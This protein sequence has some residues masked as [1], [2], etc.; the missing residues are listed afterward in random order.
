[1]EEGQ[2]PQAA[3]RGTD[4]CVVMKNTCVFSFLHF[5]C[6]LRMRSLIV[7]LA[8]LALACAAPMFAGCF[9]GYSQTA[10]AIALSPISY[11]VNVNV[12]YNFGCTGTLRVLMIG[13]WTVYD[14]TNT[15]LQYQVDGN[16]TVVGTW[17]TIYGDN[18]A[19]LLNIDVDDEYLTYGNCTG[20]F[21]TNPPGTLPYDW[22]SNS[23]G[24]SAV[25][26]GMYWYSQQVGYLTLIPDGPVGAEITLGGVL[27][28]IA[29]SSSN[30]IWG[31]K[32]MTLGPY[33]CVTCAP[34]TPAPSTGAPTPPPTPP[35]TPAPLPPTPFPGVPTPAPTPAPPT[36]APPTPAPTPAPGAPAKACCRSECVLINPSDPNQLCMEIPAASSCPAGYTLSNTGT[37]GSACM[38]SPCV[39]AVCGT[40]GSSYIP[41]CGTYIYYT[42]ATFN[43]P[44]YWRAFGSSTD[45]GWCNSFG[46]CGGCGGGPP[47]PPP[48]PAPTPPAPTPAPATQAC[49]NTQTV[50][51]PATADYFCKDLPVD[52]SLGMCGVGYY[53]YWQDGGP[54]SSCT[55][56]ASCAS[57]Q[58]TPGTSCSTNLLSAADCAASG[59]SWAG[60]GNLNNC[61]VTDGYCPTGYPIEYGVGVC[62]AATTASANGCS[63][64][65]N[66]SQQ[67]IYV[68]AGSG[69][70]TCSFYNMEYLGA[71]TVCADCQS[72]CCCSS[73]VELAACA[74]NYSPQEC[75]DLSAS[76]G[77]SCTWFGHNCAGNTAPPYTC[78]FAGPCADCSICA[79]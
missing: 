45:P 34:A 62:C 64:S 1:M 21:D 27:Q 70:A 76:V 29:I 9:T 6:L 12:T 44:S 73:G 60:Q 10:V 26:S 67:C 3:G 78:P 35:P 74:N 37:F 8:F 48:T 25:L 72:T 24:L 66:S 32:A 53:A 7:L 59:A 54:G 11:V 13:I 14:P 49:C 51:G 71:G 15:K 69:G 47:P 55:G 39:S 57:Y 40:V 46:L 33:P 43:Y 65:T 77:V 19:G 23:F 38:F 75:A 18:S 68:P 22:C 28:P 63:L 17:N 58:C 41:S 36:P 4:G 30:T 79:P 5:G 56:T 42:A 16:V 50:I 61:R 31:L 2:C 52:G 20:L